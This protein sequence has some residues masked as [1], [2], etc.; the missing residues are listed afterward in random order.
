MSYIK[1][2]KKLRTAKRIKQKDMIPESTTHS[3]YTKIEN[4]TNG[5]R[6]EQLEKMFEI[7][8]VSP[9]E[10]FHMSYYDSGV[11]KVLRLLKK[12]A[13]NPKDSK[14]E[15]ELL[16]QY[17]PS[18]ISIQQMKKEQLVYYV[19]FKNEFSTRRDDI[20]K[21]SPEEVNYVCS[22]I[23]NTSYY[24]QYDYTIALNS[25]KHMNETQIDQIISLMF[26]LEDIEE[27]IPFVINSAFCILT[28]AITYFI[29]NMNYKKAWYYI[30]LA[31]TM[32][33]KTTGYYSKINLEYNKCVVKRFLEKDIKY[34]EQARYIIKV[35][36]AIGDEL[37]AKAL[38][39]ELNNLNTKADYYLDIDNYTS[40]P[41][42]E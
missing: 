34:I 18:N 7:L 15:N 11:D 16:K 38:E 22:L 32:V 10:F 23:T 3:A 28:N 5:L 19:V 40:V 42:N 29:Y 24:T 39:Q 31:D 21:L 14:L 33:Q 30:E 25:L 41:I 9:E 6:L 36:R 12:S 35:T 37:T 8:E 27:R 13:R 4:G 17:Y 1:S 20:S 26:P 2:L